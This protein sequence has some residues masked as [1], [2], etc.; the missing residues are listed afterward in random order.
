MLEPRGLVNIAELAGSGRPGWP[1]KLL[2]YSRPRSGGSRREEKAAEAFSQ[3]RHE[4][5]HLRLTLPRDDRVS[6]LLSRSPAPVFDAVMIR[7]EAVT[8]PP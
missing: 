4:G 5:T 1:S 8:H 6:N 7:R 3:E 2:P